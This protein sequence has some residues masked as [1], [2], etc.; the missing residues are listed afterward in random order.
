[1]SLFFCNMVFIPVPCCSRAGWG[2]CALSHCPSSHTTP[3]RALVHNHFL[4]TSCVKKKPKH[5][6]ALKFKYASGSCQSWWR[7]SK[8][9]HLK[10]EVQ[11][12]LSAQTCVGFL[13]NWIFACVAEGKGHLPAGAH[14]IDLLFGKPNS[15]LWRPWLHC[16][17]LVLQGT[18]LLWLLVLCFPGE[19]LVEI[20]CDQ[21][22]FYHRDTERRWLQLT[23]HQPCW[24]SL[25]ALFQLQSTQE[26]NTSKCLPLGK[27]DPFHLHHS[28]HHP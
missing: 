13:K 1:M 14:Q 2:V 21:M 8:W 3:W 7:V 20:D 5:S 16:L 15:V 26:A 6:N 28:Y 24:K 23:K 17:Q 10:K 12:L 4:P 18:G 25:V 9:S 22:V 19:C 27:S 11:E